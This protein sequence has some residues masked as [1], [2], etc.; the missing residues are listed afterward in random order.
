M[1]TE[2]GVEFDR[3]SRSAR[4]KSNSSNSSAP[5]ERIENPALGRASYGKALLDEL[6]RECGGMTSAR[7]GRPIGNRPHIFVT[8]KRFSFEVV[9][10]GLAEHK[11]H[12]VTAPGPILRCGLRQETL[13]PPNNW[14][15]KNPSSADHL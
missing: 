11:D 1:L 10:G 15:S 12:F 9:P 14:T 7:F 4:F 2:F 8:A 3:S 13:A 5:R 6:I